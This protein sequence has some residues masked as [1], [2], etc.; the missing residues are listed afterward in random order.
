MTDDDFD[1]EVVGL[2][3]RYSDK[4]ASAMSEN[5]LDRAVAAHEAELRASEETPAIWKN[6]LRFDIQESDPDA[7]SLQQE[8]KEA[9]NLWRSLKLDLGDLEP[10]GDQIPTINT[11]WAAINQAQMQWIKKSE[12]GFGKAKTQLFCFF[13]TM[14]SHKYLFS[15]I[16]NGDKYTSLITGVITS[17]ASVNHENMA[18]GFSR[19]L[20]DISRDLNFVRRGTLLCST[21]EMKGHIVL[22]YREVFAFLCYTLKWYSS[23]WNRFRK[24]FDSRFYDKNVEQRVKRIQGLVQRVRDEINL[25]SDTMVQ[26]I[27][28]EQRAG[29][30]ATAD[31]I[32]TRIDELEGGLDAKF[33][34]FARSLGEQMCKTLMANAQHELSNL[35]N[36]RLL[37]HDSSDTFSINLATPTIT[38][39]K[40][41]L[42]KF[43]PSLAPFISPAKGDSSWNT[44]RA[45][46]PSIPI[47]VATD[48]QR[49]IQTPGS[50]ILWVEGPAYGPFEEILCSMGT[51]IWAEAEKSGIPC[52]GFFARAKY[53]FKPRAG[54]TK[55]GGLI[56]MLY[57]II[58]QL[59]SMVP[60]AFPITPS[61][62]DDMMGRLNG[63]VESIPASLETIRALLSIINPGLVCVLCKFDL[64]DSHENLPSLVE[65]MKI[66]RDQP[67]ERRFKTFII[68]SGNCRALVSTTSKQQRS[69]AS[70][71]VLG[72]H[73]SLLHG[74]VAPSDIDPQLG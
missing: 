38:R 23:S 65:F 54:S 16:P 33:A 44:A 64:V 58:D 69:D 59:I 17:I 72:G 70:R 73:G 68:S 53:A 10:F 42:E 35:R 56:S 5:V 26:N 71:L 55:T 9:A 51:G 66:L 14:D 47:E 61:L 37:R 31:L 11:L 3:R 60:R 19:A 49:S 74:G 15:I 39:T 20:Q 7:A 25:M 67:Q 41:E 43:L 2:V 48:I 36:G 22:L 18:E 52:I 40:T 50:T 12:S 8:A 63:S 28:S 4:I 6:W 46:M 29:F 27:H 62:A 24:A 30:D 32:N 1:S 34:E 21:A 57:T 45:S 13:E